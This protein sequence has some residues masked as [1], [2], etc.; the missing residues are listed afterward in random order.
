MEQFQE[1]KAQL[2]EAQQKVDALSLRERGLILLAVLAALYLLWD[3]L[4]MAPLRQQGSLMENRYQ[5]QENQ[6]QALRAEITTLSSVAGL[7]PDRA[8]KREVQKLEQTLE[9]VDER[10]SALSQ[11]LV[12]A[13]QLPRVLEDVLRRSSELTL[14]RV[15]TLP[16]QELALGVTTAEPDA[17]ENFRAFDDPTTSD[18][19]FK[20]SVSLRVKGSFPQTLAYLK[21]LEQLPWRF[22]WD[23]LSYSVAEYPQA[24][25]ELRVYTLS[26]EEGLLGV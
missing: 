9:A 23:W 14:V 6:K 10:L 16:V 13:D 17:G 26:A 18:G 15:Q 7:D 4:V 2:K 3:A 24:E 22:Y 19:V 21:A 1:L 11:G 25:I 5:Q 8:E 20:H 12:S